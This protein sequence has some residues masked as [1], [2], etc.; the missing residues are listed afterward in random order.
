MYIYPKKQLFFDDMRFLINNLKIVEAGAQGTHK[1]ARGYSP[2]I[3]YIKRYW[4]KAKK[5]F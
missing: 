1:I 2:E 5:F 3:T 4:M